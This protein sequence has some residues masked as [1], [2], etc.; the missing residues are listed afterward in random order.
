MAESN[1]VKICYN[2]EHA[3]YS[4][5]KNHIACSLMFVKHRGSWEKAMEDLKLDSLYTGWGFLQRAVDDFEGKEPGTGIMANNVVL[6]EK[7]FCCKY[8]ESR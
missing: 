5:T 8:H 3:R 2:C 7:D 1:R 6:F 4:K